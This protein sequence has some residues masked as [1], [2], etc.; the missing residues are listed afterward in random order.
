M[1]K[2][3]RDVLGVQKGAGCALVT[4]APDASGASL[5]ISDSLVT[6]VTSKI[7]CALINVLQVISQISQKVSVQSAIQGA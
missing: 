6:L 7:F 3:A 2:P 4:R 5:V 1:K